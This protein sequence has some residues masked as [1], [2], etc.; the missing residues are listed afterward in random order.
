MSVCHLSTLFCFFF[1]TILIIN[2]L[3]LIYFIKINL[4]LL[5][6]LELYFLIIFL[7]FLYLII[8][9]LCLVLILFSYIILI[10]FTIIRIKITKFVTFWRHLK[11]CLIN[12]LLI[13]WLKWLRK[14]KFITAACITNLR[15]FLNL[16]KIQ[17]YFFFKFYKKKYF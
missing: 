16:I 2:S 10:N 9:F 14:V 5:F 8:S 6:C 11:T 3:T 1:R 17:I 15:W 4:N 12:R 13:L 7:L